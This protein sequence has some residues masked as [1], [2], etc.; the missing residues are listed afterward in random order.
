MTCE[1]FEVV[2]NQEDISVPHFGRSEGYAFNSLD[3]P[4]KGLHRRQIRPSG[5]ESERGKAYSRS[6]PDV[7]VEQLK[8]E[9]ISRCY[10]R[11]IS[12]I[13]IIQHIAS[14]ARKANIS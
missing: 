12:Q 14:V 2:L 1:L 8:G 13:R 5:K 4:L 3:I 10:L 11:N 6:S 7:I 9:E